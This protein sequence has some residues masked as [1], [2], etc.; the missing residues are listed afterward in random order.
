MDQEL[1]NGAKNA[2]ITKDLENKLAKSDQDR[3]KLEAEL[4]EAL[5]KHQTETKL[6]TEKLIDENLKFTDYKTIKERVLAQRDS[7]IAQLKE[8]LVRGAVTPTP[9]S[10]S[11]PQIAA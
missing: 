3:R 4:Q 9:K 8:R 5:T 11:L 2:E 7:E 10:D 6:L 1:R